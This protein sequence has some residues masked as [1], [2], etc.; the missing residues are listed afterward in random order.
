MKSSKPGIAIFT[1]LKIIIDQ[2]NVDVNDFL[3]NLKLTKNDALNMGTFTKI[4]HLIDENIGE[5]EMKFLYKEFNTSINDALTFEEFSKG[6]CKI[7]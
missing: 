1:R 6:L 3:R 2:K 5:K 7:A 4:V